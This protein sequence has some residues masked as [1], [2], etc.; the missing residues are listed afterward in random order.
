MNLVRIK[1][2]T[3]IR[4]VLLT[5]IKQKAQTILKNLNIKKIIVK[6]HLKLKITFKVN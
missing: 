4:K 2:K 3:K 5:F 1:N 6:D